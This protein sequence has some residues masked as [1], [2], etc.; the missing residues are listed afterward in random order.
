MEM[1]LTQQGHAEADEEEVGGYV[2]TDSSS[3]DSDEGERECVPRQFYPPTA[4]NG[5]S[6]F[7]KINGRSCCIT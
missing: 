6:F 7:C 3:S 4:P 1:D 5:F 2:T